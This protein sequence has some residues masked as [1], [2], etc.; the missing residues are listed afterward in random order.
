MGEPFVLPDWP[1]RMSAAQAAAY[2]NVGESTLRHGAGTRYPAPLRDGK[3]VV[4]DRKMLD[5]W[6]DAEAGLTA[7]KLG[8][9]PW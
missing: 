4:W 8:L 1:R 7:K 6:A 3:R 2:L 5:D 9:K